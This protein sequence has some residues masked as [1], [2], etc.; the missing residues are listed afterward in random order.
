MVALCRWVLLFCLIVAGGNAVATNAEQSNQSSQSATETSE[1]KSEQS[2]QERSVLESVTEGIGDA[3]GILTRKVR[4]EGTEGIPRKIAVLP[5]IGQGD[6]RE[7]DDIR[8]AI[9]NNLSSKNFELLKPFDID[10]VLTQ[11]EQIDG[12][13]PSDF[14]PKALAQKL[15]VE[16]LIYVDVP[17]VERVYAAAY[18]HYKITI[19]LSFYSAAEDDYIWEKQESIAE[20]EGGISLN[21][22]SF[23]AQAISSAQVLTEAVRQSLVDKL[24][25]LF[26]GE[27][28]FP[29]GERRKVKPVKINMAISNASEGPFRA[30][31]EI[32]VF[33]KAEPGL[34]ATFD[35]GNQFVGLPMTEQGQG[36]YI[37]RYVV[38]DN[39]NAENLV[40]RIYATRVKDKAKIEWRVAGRIGID[41]IVPEAIAKIES[42]PVKDGIRLSWSSATSKQE[43][44]T[45]H[46]ERADPQLGTYQD[47]AAINIQEYID[48]DIVE[49][50]NYHYRI[51]AMDEAKNKSPYTNLQVSAVGAGPTE[52]VD[53]ILS[54]TIWHAVASPYIVKENIRILRGAKLTLS[55]GVIV[56][57]EQGGQLEVLGQLEAL[58]PSTQP[59]VFDGEDWTLLFASTGESQSQFNHC[60]FSG[61]RVVVDQSTLLFDD[62]EFRDMSKALELSNNAQVSLTN[63]EFAHNQVAIAAQ[64]GNL[65]LNR[66]RFVDNELALDI[67][68]ELTLWN[69][70]VRFAD[71]QVHI[72]AAKA[73]TIKNAIFDAPDYQ[74]L[75]ARLDGD[76]K[77]DFSGLKGEHNLL[78][79]WLKA[80]WEEVLA[81]ATEQNWQAASDNLAALSAEVGDDQRVAAF[82]QATEYVLG[83]PVNAPVDFVQNIESFD[84]GGKKGL[85]WVHQLQLR[86]SPNIA[87]ADSYLIKQAQKNFTKD[88]LKQRYPELKPVQLMKYRRG[89]SLDKSIVDSQVLYTNKKGMFLQLWLAYYLDLEAIDRQ[90]TAAGLIQRDNSSLVV[91]LLFDSEMFELEQQLVDAFKEQGIKYRSLGSG[92]YGKPMQKKAQK[93]GV[94][95]VLALSSKT[96]EGGSG[97]LKNIVQVNV[98]LVVEIFDVLSNNNL[99]R[100]TA[101]ST[102]SGFNKQELIQDAALEAYG[103]IDGQLI[104]ILWQADETI[105]AELARLAAEKAQRER[106][107]RLAEEKARKAQARKKAE[108]ERL[109]KLKQEQ[110]R[111]AKLA[112]AKAA[113]EAAQK[114][115][116]EKAKQEEAAR[117]KAEQ[118]KTA[119]AQSQQDQEQAS[120]DI[121]D[122]EQSEQKEPPVNQNR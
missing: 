34:A 32:S 56:R 112:A 100:L 4:T 21:P 63:G 54:D 115:A 47:I 43:T 33:M 107:Q 71:N 111:I 3:I 53:D 68:G 48:R 92:I 29:L 52:V 36:D 41:T 114:A 104:N 82:S 99:D 98:D 122:K 69:E 84:K 80:R 61:G 15:D 60:K 13:T 37:G 1:Q 2:E 50:T 95:V 79:S 26:A 39:D 10:R 51:Y 67:S 20:R 70:A 77:V 91:G 73:M 45:Y 62:V 109:A 22:L 72:R 31:E 88:Y 49:G 74:Q 8:T 30:G 40:V 24:A 117:Q 42:S 113:K 57:F 102:K 12:S 106:Q 96:S 11:L 66:V 75:M 7:R 118:A 119:K 103:T 65:N 14:D 64:D 97:L 105:S 6:E 121:G 58:A 93:N 55:P 17:L 16:G 59:I 46:I 83:K 35:I 120:E 89:L 90:L 5:A 94:N 108:Q 38:G 28:P 87:E 85:L 81:A 76:I 116:E 25:R 44:L 101:S 23:I 19:K 78:E 27:I 86:F 9:H 18:A 110:E